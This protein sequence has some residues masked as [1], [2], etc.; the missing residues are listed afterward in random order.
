MYCRTASNGA[1]IKDELIEV[2]KQYANAS[3]E[4]RTVQSTQVAQL[5]A[6]NLSTIENN[7]SNMKYASSGT[8]N[9]QEIRRA[10][11][12]PSP[13]KL[14]SSSKQQSR[15]M[16]SGSPN[17]SKLAIANTDGSE[18]I[19]ALTK[20]CNDLQIKSE[21][22]DD[23]ETKIAELTKLCEN[24]QNKLVT[25]EDSETKI[26]AISKQCKYLQD[27]LMTQDATVA[28]LAHKVAEYEKPIEDDEELEEP[29]T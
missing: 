8:M 9:F 15:F 20:Q 25:Q 7:K 18:T 28:E 14:G 4:I 27:K 23:S 29:Y 24:L 2:S 13:N 3:S 1:E 10:H 19:A 5:T 11:K 22:Q 17:A 21:T 6:S 12:S 16:I 26:A